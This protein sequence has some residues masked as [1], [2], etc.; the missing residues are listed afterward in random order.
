MHEKWVEEF[1]DTLRYKAFFGVCTRGDEGGSIA[2]LTS[3]QSSRLFTVD[4][5]ALNH[6]LMNVAVWQKPGPARRTACR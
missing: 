2:F 4:V 3:Q 1:G 6:V 5:K